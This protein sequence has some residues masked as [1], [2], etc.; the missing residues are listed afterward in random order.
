MPASPLIVRFAAFGDVVLLT[1][2][3]EIL[4]RRYGRPVDL[5]SSGPWTEP[6][7]RTDPRI[8]HVQLVSSR[9]A[10]YAFCRSQRRAVQWLRGRD[11]GPVYLCEPDAKSQW[12]LDH[13]GIAP[14]R[15]VRAFDHPGDGQIHFTDWWLQIGRLTP[16]DCGALEPLDGMAVDPVPRLHLTDA[17]RRECR[18][19]LR[20]CGL[21]GAPLLLMQSGNKRTY[22]RGRLA[23]FNDNKWWPIE[24]WAAVARQLIV[25]Q[26]GL[27]ILLCGA[28][29][30]AGVLQEIR[31]RANYAGVRDCSRDLTVRRL[32]ALLEVA[33]GMISVD[34]GPAHAAA[35]MDCPLVVM[36]GEQDQRV[37][38]PRSRRGAVIALGGEAGDASRIDDLSVADVMHAWRR[39]EK[40]HAPPTPARALTPVPELMP[41]PAPA[42]APAASGLRSTVRSLP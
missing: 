6:L 24:R 5:L 2:L 1:T 16:A 20:T 12:L 28:P 21:D 36:F 31:A 22:K 15:T 3:V 40:R 34:T 10:A 26:P 7:L 35:A 4:H 23:S 17:D 27:R 39:L 37:W 8:G 9:K 41:A 11:P 30:E 14:G 38:R 29:S 25:E 19:W 32:L 33:Q 18:A 42:A 13:A